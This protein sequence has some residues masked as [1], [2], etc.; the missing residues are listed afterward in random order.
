M[1]KKTITYPDYNGQTRTEDFFFHFSEAELMEM[2]LSVHGGFSERVKKITDAKDQPALIK[3]IKE[4]VLDAHGIKSEDG[5]RFMKNE[6]I[7]TAFVENPA[8][9]IIFMELARD[10]KAAAEFVN[11]VVPEHMKKDVSAATAAVISASSE[12]KAN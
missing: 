4:F 12:T 9:S 2:Q 5:K 6:E 7:R 10:D 3:L 11:G 8:Y 1:I